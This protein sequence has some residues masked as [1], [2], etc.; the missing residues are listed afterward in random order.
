MKRGLPKQAKKEEDDKLAE[1]LKKERHEK[2]VAAAQETLNKQPKTDQEKDVAEVHPNLLQ[3][4][5]LY[6]IVY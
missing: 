3:W 6:A 4:T 2:D 1:A 5:L